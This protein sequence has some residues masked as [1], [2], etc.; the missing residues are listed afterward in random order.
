MAVEDFIQGFLATITVDGVDQTLIIETGGLARTKTVLSKGSMDGTGFMKSIPGP[1]SGTLNIA[2]HIQA[3]NLND[4]EFAYA[5]DVPVAFTMTIEA[6]AVTTDPSYSG[7]VV[8][9]EFNVETTAD[10]NWSYTLTGET[11]GV[12]AYVPFVNV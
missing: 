12:I 6:F 1:T 4:L 11:S 10:G 2:G 9:S 8:I 7:T 5:K 3:L